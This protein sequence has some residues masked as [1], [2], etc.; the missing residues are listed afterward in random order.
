ML[1]AIASAEYDRVIEHAGMVRNDGLVEAD[2][3]RIAAETGS[4]AAKMPSRA[5]S[6]ARI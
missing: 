1:L 3:G 5:P 6:L 2:A 4:P